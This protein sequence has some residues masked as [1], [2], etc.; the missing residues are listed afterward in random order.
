MN[1][2]NAP[3]HKW[4]GTHYPCCRS[5]PQS[6]IYASHPAR[7]A[8]YYMSA[9]LVQALALVAV[10]VAAV[11]KPYPHTS[12]N[13]CNYT[14][15]NNPTCSRDNSVCCRSVSVAA[16]AHSVTCYQAACYPPMAV[17]YRYAM[18]NSSSSHRR[19]DP[20]HPNPNR[21]YTCLYRC[22]SPHSCAE[23]N[24][25]CC[26]EGRGYLMAGQSNLYCCGCSYSHLHHIVHAG[27]ADLQ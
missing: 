8:R 16:M 17:C 27:V 20:E 25:N 13:S 4:I 22:N 14:A 15:M 10:V 2:D 6:R 24:P 3:V 9:A 26:L 11:L 19:S 12:Q 18:D 5:Y 1:S 21:P 23:N 7:H